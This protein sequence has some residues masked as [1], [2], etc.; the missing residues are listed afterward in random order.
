[1]A[2]LGRPAAPRLRY[3]PSSRFLAG[4]LVADP[5]KEVVEVAAGE[6]PLE[7]SGDRAVTVLEGEELL[8]LRTGR[9]S[10][11]CSTASLASAP[12]WVSV[13]AD[14]SV[15]DQAVDEDAPEP[16]CST[17]LPTTSTA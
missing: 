10:W 15:G 14:Q 3:Q 13:L 1:M 16:G 4:L 12:S 2:G 5:G 9:F 8:D 11:S 6:L 17:R 7:R